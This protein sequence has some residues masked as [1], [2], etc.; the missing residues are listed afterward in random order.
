MHLEYVVAIVLD[1]SDVGSVCQFIK[2]LAKWNQ[3]QVSKLFPCTSKHGKAFDW[4]LNIPTVIQ[5]KISTKSTKRQ[6]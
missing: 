4:T 2:N 5:T 6:K 3:F 1:K